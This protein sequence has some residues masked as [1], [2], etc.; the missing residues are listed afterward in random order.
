MWL[1]LCSSGDEPALWAYHGLRA[2]GLMPLELVS[3]E[4]LASGVRW[5]HRLEAGGA[6]TEITLPDGRTISSTDTRGVL[7]RLVSLPHEPLTMAHPADRDYATQEF[8]AFYLSW[9]YSFPEPVLNRP[10]PVGLAG[11]W[12]HTSEWVWLASQAGLPVPEYR[13]SSWDPADPM[14]YQSLVPPGTGANTIIVVAGHVVGAPSPL[15]IVEGCRRL[16]ELAQTPLLGVDFAPGAAGSWTFARA[17][18]L[19]DLRLGGQCLLDALAT[20]F[21]GEE[22]KNG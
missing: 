2:G 21:K 15:H 20:V 10:T 8:T 5:D 6:S 4:M 16:S 3:T 11:Q 19:P 7:N 14:E 13:Q 18:P 12:R 1:V 22:E 9:L 17:T